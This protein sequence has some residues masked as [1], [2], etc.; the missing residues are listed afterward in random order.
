MQARGDEAWRKIG[1]NDAVMG[2]LNRL[3]AGGISYPERESMNKIVKSGVN[4][5]VCGIM[6]AGGFFVS[7]RTYLEYIADE[8][9]AE[10]DV[11]TETAPIDC[12]NEFFEETGV[13]SEK[14][15]YQLSDSDE[16]FLEE[17]LYGHWKVSKRIS[18]LDET[19]NIYDYDKNMT[20]DTHTEEPS[21][22][23]YQVTTD[24]PNPI[25]G[26]YAIDP[27]YKEN[28]VTSAYIHPLWGT[29][30]N[31]YDQ[32]DL[33]LFGVY[34]GFNLDITNPIYRVETI[35]ADEAYLIDLMDAPGAELISLNNLFESDTVIR[36]TYD[37][38]QNESFSQRRNFGDILYVVDNGDR[39]TLYLDFCGLWE[40]KRME[41]DNKMPTNYQS[42]R[43]Y[44]KG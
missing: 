21:K 13:S 22:L 19:R 33:Y 28:M 25:Y 1:Q 11:A 40:M 5:L 41:P 20:Y 26:Y 15:N 37:L 32:S 24:K 43:A 14:E 38:G 10:T 42:R 29:P 3:L 31:F 44:L 9:P 35:R 7:E 16:L 4:L 34:G 6:F 30:A 2:M 12:N 18:A 36:I 39:D 8:S 27:I 17:H 23:Y